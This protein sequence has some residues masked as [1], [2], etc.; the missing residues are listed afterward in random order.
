MLSPGQDLFAT[1][2]D[3]GGFPALA[4]QPARAMRCAVAFR[5]KAVLLDR[6]DREA[7]LVTLDE[8]S[9]LLPTSEKR[10]SRLQRASQ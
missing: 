7:R 8:D 1:T 10:A 4:S 9:P 2:A 5:A 3:D 6:P